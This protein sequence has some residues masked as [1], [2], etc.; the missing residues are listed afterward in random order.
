MNSLNYTT[1][2]SGSRITLIWA[3]LPSNLSEFNLK[4]I[5]FACI[6]AKNGEKT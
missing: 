3:N 1:L 6:I 2:F 5:K 4:K